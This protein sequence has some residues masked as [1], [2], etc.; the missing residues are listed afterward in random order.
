MTTTIDY[1]AIIQAIL[2]AADPHTAMHRFVQRQGDALLCNG[3]EYDLA[4]IERIIVVGAGKAS[5]RMAEAIEEILGD[6][7]ETGLVI[8]KDG[9]TSPTKRIRIAEAAHPVP[10][11][12]SPILVNEIAQLLGTT[13]K[14]D[15]VLCLISGGGSALMAAPI[16]NLIHLNDIQQLTTL[17]LRSGAAIQEINTV[18]KHLMRFSGGRLAALA[19]P[20]RV[21][22][23]IISD[24]VGSPLSMIASGPTVPEETSCAD[25]LSILEK[26]HLTTKI[27]PVILETLRLSVGEHPTSSQ[28]IWNLVQNVIISDNTL[29]AEAAANAARNQGFLTT[30]QTTSLEGEA[31]TVGENIT[32]I[33]KEIL[34]NNIHA[35]KPTCMIFSGETT[36]TVRGTGKGGRN[37]ELALAAAIALEGLEQI[38]LLV[39]ATDGTDGPTDAAG[40]IISGE[41]ASQARVQG[42]DAQTFLNN[43]NSYTLLEMTTSLIKTVPTNTNVNDVVMLFVV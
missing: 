8:V 18:R 16:T 26:Y 3:E 43:N 6:R 11:E 23:L 40:A 9:Y 36:V 7:I 24:I 32:Q 38:S 29:A 34:T 17:L 42:L 25:A 4:K 22:S 27:A 31:R 10:D 30:I 14:H 28:S 13:T 39:L 2:T 41:T 37:Q 15:L 19:A 35:A 12:R 33:A 1:N 21:L 20:A 5:G